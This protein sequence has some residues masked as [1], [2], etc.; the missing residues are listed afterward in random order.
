MLWSTLSKS[1]KMK[2]VSLW[3]DLPWS[4]MFSGGKGIDFDQ[5]GYGIN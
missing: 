4:I 3:N 5:Y 2:A 1:K